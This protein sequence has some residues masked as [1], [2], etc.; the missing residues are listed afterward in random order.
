[1]V[2]RPR[3]CSWLIGHPEFPNLT[4]GNFK[5]ASDPDDDYNCIAWA[6]DRKDRPWWPTTIAPYFW[7]DGLPKD[8]PNI[9][10]TIENFIK[11]FEVQ[12]YSVCR[13]GRFSWR[14]EKVAIYVDDHDVPTHAARTL[15]NHVWSSKMGDEEDIEHVTYADV[16]G[17][18]YGKAK[19]YLKR[20][21]P[22]DRKPKLRMFDL[23]PLN[24]LGRTRKKFSPIPKLSPTAS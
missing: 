3:D 15:P 24:L 2:H 14:Y 8:P 13:N 18:K 21:W 4:A 17:T 10:E 23:F 1:M 9:A 16:E 6:A 19:I 11:A 22:E 12:G 20:K 7:P 5:C